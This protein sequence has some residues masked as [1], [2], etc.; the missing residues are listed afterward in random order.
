MT[1]TLVVVSKVKKYIK[2]KGDM[3]TSATAIE[4]LTKI[5]E[6]ECE[7]AI[8]AAQQSK[9]KTVLDRDFVATES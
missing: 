5:V 8:A 1:E 3:N 6:K 2:D 4:A 7:K 9:R